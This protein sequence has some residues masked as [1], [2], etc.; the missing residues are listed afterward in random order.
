[1]KRLPEDDVVD[2]D[3]ARRPIEPAMARSTPPTT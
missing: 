3:V 2:L 1:M